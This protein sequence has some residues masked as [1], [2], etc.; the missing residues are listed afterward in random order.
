T[1]ART[2]TDHQ[3]LLEQPNLSRPPQPPP[4]PQ[5]LAFPPNG[6]GQMFVIWRGGKC[7]VLKFDDVTLLEPK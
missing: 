1:K 3:I 6:Q 5:D 2:E 7:T 4:R